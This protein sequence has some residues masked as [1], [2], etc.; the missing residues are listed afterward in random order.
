MKLRLIRNATL[1]LEYAGMTWLVDPMFSE[2][3]ANP[4]IPHTAN[5]RRNPLVDLPIELA[6]LS[7]PDVVVLTHRHLD[8]WD[9]PAAEFLPKE[10]LFLCQPP[11]E[12]P[13]IQ[14][15]GFSQV[16]PVI[17]QT[18]VN[19][20]TVI[21]VH[22]QH[23]RGEI[24]E[25]MA[26]VSGYVWKA[27]GE[28]VLYLTSDTIWC[29]SVQETLDLQQPE[30]VVVHAGGAEFLEGGP[31]IMNVEDVLALLAHAPAAQVTAVHM[32]AINHCHVTREELRQ[33]VDQA[34]EG[35]RVQIPEDGE[36]VSFP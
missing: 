17:G 31:I 6:E 29:D 25:R 24:G 5:E 10:V 15:Y 27:P 14:T 33:R 2:K 35:G 9:A 8:H 12:L 19:G 32:E 22:A 20:V 26:P 18:E 7:I 4:P 30:V 36:W 3:G 13:L 21:R 23:G 34:G 28:P 16:V 11:D 1:W